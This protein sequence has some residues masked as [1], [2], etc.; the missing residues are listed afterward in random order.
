MRNALWIL[1]L[2]CLAPVVS[3]ADLKVL[4][5]VEPSCALQFET[6]N[7][8]VSIFNESGDD[9]VIDEGN[10]ANKAHISFVVERKRDEPVKRLDDVSPVTK[11]RIASG[12]KQDFVTDISARY[13]VAQTGRYLIRVVVEDGKTRYESLPVV[14]DVVNGIEICG[15]S[16]VLPGYSDRIRRYSLRYWNRD[17]RE[18]L[19]LCVTEDNGRT[20]YG[21]FPLGAV[22]RVMKPNVLVDKDGTVVVQHQTTKDCF[23]QSFFD[24]NPDGVFFVEQKYKSED[25]KPYPYVSEAPASKLDKQK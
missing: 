21:V 12:E 5:R 20:S 9:L 7:V 14:L 6:V 17:K 8:G 2:C 3:L 18:R 4:L 23:V 11:M 1:V 15:V 19:F 13:D 16:K 24:S 25:G 10:K 22:I